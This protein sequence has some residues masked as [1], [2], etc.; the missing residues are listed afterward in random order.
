M[1]AK[2]VRGCECHTTVRVRD[3]NNSVVLKTVA[4][5]GANR[6]EIYHLSEEV[7]P[8]ARLC[9][10]LPDYLNGLSMCMKIGE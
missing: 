3:E 9:G 2:G 6:T 8:G 7:V 4:I 1:A 10:Q 5:E